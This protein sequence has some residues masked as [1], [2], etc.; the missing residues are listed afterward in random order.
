MLTTLRSLRRDG[1]PLL[2]VSDLHPIRRTTPGDQFLFLGTFIRG[3]QSF[4]GKINAFGVERL[5]GSGKAMARS[6]VELFFRVPKRLLY[7]FALVCIFEPSLEPT[8]IAV[9]VRDALASASLSVCDDELVSI[10]S[11]ECSPVAS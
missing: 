8:L 11:P 2:P 4:R 10:T 9:T 6:H 1:T 3:S 7:Y 5:L